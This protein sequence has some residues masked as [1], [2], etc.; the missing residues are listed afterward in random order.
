MRERKWVVVVSMLVVVST[1]VLA[2]WLWTDRGQ[3][4]AAPMNLQITRVAP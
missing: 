3:A 1:I 4:P 2:A